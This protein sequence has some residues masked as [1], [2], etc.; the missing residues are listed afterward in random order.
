MRSRAGRQGVARVCQ[1]PRRCRADSLQA[2]VCSEAGGCV[3]KKLQS[4]CTNARRQPRP[5]WWPVRAGCRHSARPS[6]RSGPSRW[7]E[8]VVPDAHG[9]VGRE[10]SPLRLP[11]VHRQAPLTVAV[12]AA[13]RFFAKDAVP[14]RPRR[15]W[16][17]QSRELGFSLPRRPLRQQFA[18]HARG[19]LARRQVIRAQMDSRGDFTAPGDRMPG[20][21]RGLDSGSGSVRGGKA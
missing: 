13:L 21:I 18:R 9:A 12:L 19:W 14:I 2:G 7:V 8:A 3:A 4:D 17:A 6:P 10:T 15:V 1:K 16:R 5:S 20:G 11:S